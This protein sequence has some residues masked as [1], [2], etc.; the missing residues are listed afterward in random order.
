[1]I[2]RL[3]RL[4]RPKKI[5][6]PR[7]HRPAF[8][9]RHRGPFLVLGSAPSIISHAEKISRFIRNH[10]PIVLSANVPHTV[11]WL[12]TQYVGFTNRKRLGQ[13]R[14]FSS[15]MNTW[16]LI[17]PHIPAQAVWM[18]SWERMPF[19]NDADAPFDIVDGII[20]C[21]CHECGWLL[22]AVAYVMGA[23]E[24]W[25]AGYDGYR[26]GASNHFYDQPDFQI[27]NSLRRQSTIQSTL[28]PQMREMFA[29]MRVD[30]PHFLTP[31]V[32]AEDA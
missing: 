26:R 16:C 12:T 32:Y 19:V 21:S 10:R 8:M 23:S 13:A 7:L 4:V 11:S 28:L 1:M 5:L 17:G 30:G 9:H 14:R 15:L 24:I 18:P 29:A 6:H 25:M 20:Q 3:R 27:E 22:T 31:S 2:E